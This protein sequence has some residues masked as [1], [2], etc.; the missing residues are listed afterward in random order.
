[1]RR[2]A[3]RLTGN[4]GGLGGPNSPARLLGFA[5]GLF[6][7]AFHGHGV[8]ESALPA[9]QAGAEQLFVEQSL[10][11]PDVGQLAPESIFA[12]AVE[13]KS[14]LAAGKKGCA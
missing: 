9:R 4:V 14:R 5:F 8:V 2:G 1:M 13:C 10:A 7:A 12:L 3:G 11:D 6:E